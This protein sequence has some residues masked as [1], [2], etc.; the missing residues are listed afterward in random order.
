MH[1]D[2]SLYDMLFL[3]YI[4]C[5]VNSCWSACELSYIHVNATSPL[6]MRY[7][8]LIYRD[9]IRVKQASL[10]SLCLD[11]RFIKLG[12]LFTERGFKEGYRH[13]YMD[14]VAMCL[15]AEN[16]REPDQKAPSVSLWSRSS[17]LA[18]V[19]FRGYKRNN[20]R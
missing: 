2:I 3:K 8:M 5:S 7:K 15:T 6:V 20:R 10:N 18:D 9:W 16:S 14:W 4:Y 17:P 11:Q 12:P 19:L 1:V 13:D